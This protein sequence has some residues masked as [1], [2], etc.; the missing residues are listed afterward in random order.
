MNRYDAYYPR[1][2]APQRDGDAGFVGV[3]ER[4]DEDQLPPGLVSAATNC[5]FRRGLVEPRPGITILRCLKGDGT[6]P[7]T[8]SNV[9]NVF[10][11]SPPNA[12]QDW[13]G[14]GAPF[15]PDGANDCVIGCRFSEIQQ[16]QRVNIR[17]NSD[18][19]NQVAWDS[20]GGTYNGG[21]TDCYPVGIIQ[22]GALVTTGYTSNVGATGQDFQFAISLNGLGGTISD[23]HLQVIIF[24]AATT[25]TGYVTFG[26]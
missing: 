7:F 18:P 14:T 9:A 16:L 20:M 25:M 4:I 26:P 17:L 13:V 3:D 10:K 11:I 23:C 6:T 5:R 24:T 2:T 12:Y 19:N 21:P 15:A 1:D 8:A 22:N